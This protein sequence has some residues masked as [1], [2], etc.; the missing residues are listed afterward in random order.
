MYAKIESK[1]LLP[2]ILRVN[3]DI[4][5]INTNIIVLL[6]I[7]KSINMLTLLITL[8]GNLFTTC[9]YAIN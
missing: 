3:Y 6:I 8:Y 1:I 2:L 9:R 7:N 5:F 4:N